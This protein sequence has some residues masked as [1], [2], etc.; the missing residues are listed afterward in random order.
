MA[1]ILKYGTL[2]Q[3]VAAH[4]ARYKDSVKG[5]ALALAGWLVD[6]INDGTF[7]EAQVT[8]AFGLAGHGA[9]VSFIARLQTGKNN[10]ATVQAARGE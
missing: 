5:N 4:R 8:S 3:L 10:L 1:L 7:T 9:Y 6:R 2:D